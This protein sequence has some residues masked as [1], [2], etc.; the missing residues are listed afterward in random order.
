M[1]NLFY[2]LQQYKERIGSYPVGS[3][4]EVAKALLGNNPKNLMILVGRKKDLN[5]K[6]EFV[7]PWGT[8]LKIY[9]SGRGHSRPLPFSP[10]KRS[11]DSTVLN[12]DDYY[13]SNE[14]ASNRPLRRRPRTFANRRQSCH[15]PL[16]A[17]AADERAF[18]MWISC[19][20]SQSSIAAAASGWIGF[21][22]DNGLNSGNSRVIVSA[23]SD[24][25]ARVRVQTE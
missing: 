23:T 21:A 5:S 14:T 22:N 11:D 2:A 18:P 8:P 16:S 9:F 1:D 13:R 6:G 17:R 25:S 20:Q 7:D 4:A 24:V 19:G 12:P 10:N 15:L 3:N